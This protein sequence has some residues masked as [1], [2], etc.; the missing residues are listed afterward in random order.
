MKF[1]HCV[2]LL[3]ICFRSSSRRVTDFLA[4]A[5]D[6][7]AIAA[8]GV[9]GFRLAQHLCCLYCNREHVGRTVSSFKRAAWRDLAAGDFLEDAHKRYS[10]GDCDRTLITG[11][12][13][14]A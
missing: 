3:W 10:H 13:T 8:T 4:R 7:H 11:W 14:M 9:D 2:C 12:L 6:A 5:S 1:C